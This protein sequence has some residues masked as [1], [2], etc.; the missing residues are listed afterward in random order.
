[1]GQLPGPAGAAALLVAEGCAAGDVM[2]PQRELRSSYWAGAPALLQRKLNGSCVRNC[3][4]RGRAP[5][6][7]APLPVRGPH[8]T[9]SLAGAGGSDPVGGVRLVSTGRGSSSGLGSSGRGLASSGPRFSGLGGRC[10]S[11]S[12]RASCSAAWGRSRRC[13]SGFCSVAPVDSVDRMLVSLRCHGS[14]HCRSLVLQRVDGWGPSSG[15]WGMPCGQRLNIFRQDR[16]RRRTA[17]QRKHS[18]ACR[19]ALGQPLE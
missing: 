19:W 4:A 7:V 13:A 15:G 8:R 3:C 5:V 12:A 6:W 2:L 9:G 11:T 10:H 16:S 18:P 14:D 1:M 17:R